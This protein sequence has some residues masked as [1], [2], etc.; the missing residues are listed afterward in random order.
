MATAKIFS[1]DVMPILENNCK[2]C[3]GSAG[4]FTVTTA[5][6]TYTN[7]MSLTY[8]TTNKDKG[9][10]DYS[11]GGGDK[12]NATEYQILESWIYAETMNN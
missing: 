10:G 3:H 1:T 12:L 6:E 11:H 8:G 4:N 7:I 5:S 2:S 9:D